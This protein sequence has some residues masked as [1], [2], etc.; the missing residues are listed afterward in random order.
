MNP[1]HQFM[2]CHSDRRADQVGP[3]WRNL[4]ADVA[5]PQTGGFS[6]LSL[7]SS[8]RGRNSIAMTGSEVIP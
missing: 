7:E 6:V 1:G 8:R 5:C 3:K 4:P 2:F